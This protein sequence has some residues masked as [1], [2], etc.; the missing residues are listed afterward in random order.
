MNYRDITL[1]IDYEKIG[2]KHDGYKTHLTCYEP[3]LRG[4]NKDKAVLVLPG[5][6]YFTTSDREGEPVAMEFL[7]EGFA[8]YVLWYSCNPNRHPSQAAEVGTA[9]KLIRETLGDGE[10]YLC[11]FS[12]GGHLAAFYATSFCE[13]AEKYLGCKAADIRVDGC[14]LGYPVVS[15]DD[16]YGHR[17]SFRNLLGDRFDELREYASVEKRVTPETPRM[18]VWSTYRDSAVP[19][20]NSLALCDSLERNKVPFELHIFTEGEH[21][22]SVANELV[23]PS[24]TRHEAWLKHA[25][26]WIAVK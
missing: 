21:G 6:G 17:D 8:V 19:I 13:V 26:D 1:N 9:V 18:F 5:G 3:D 25:I 7:K 12:A 4:T 23:C 10:L 11:G 2:V 24:R 22:L 14:I 20:R 16:R 15:C